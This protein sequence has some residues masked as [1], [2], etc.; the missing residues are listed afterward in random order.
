MAE[1]VFAVTQG[2]VDAPV[3]IDAI[4]REALQTEWEARPAIEG[5]PSVP[6]PSAGRPISNTQVRVVD[7][8]GH[9][10]PERKIGELAL[11]SDCMLSG[12][13]HRPDITAKAFSDGWYLTGDYGYMAD[14]EVYVCGRKKEII[15]VGGKNIYPMDLEE[16]AMGVKGRAPRAGERFR[17]LQRD[18]GHRGRGHRGR[19]GDE[20]P[21]RTRAHCR[22]DPP[23]G[24]A[25]F[26]GGFAPC[27]PGG[28][29]L[30]DQDFQRQEFP[31]AK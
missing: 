23:G 29:A 25:R 1:N 17:H 2:G 5:R 15:I 12:Y 19:G 7:S 18:L 10:L 22:R 27:T 26:G 11:K 16:L 14:G 28:A 30:A 9:D 6:M 31:T 24:D 3:T 20:R 13:Y 8:K 4:D 21:D